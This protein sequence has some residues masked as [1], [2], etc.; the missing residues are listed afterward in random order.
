MPL[1]PK[2]RSSKGTRPTPGLARVAAHAPAAVVGK[3]ASTPIHSWGRDLIFP[4]PYE[5]PA[6]G[7]QTSRVDT[8]KKA[9]VAA[10]SGGPPGKI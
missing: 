4:S 8:K 6:L 10:G 5:S 3:K 1:V 2:R 7:G 9:P